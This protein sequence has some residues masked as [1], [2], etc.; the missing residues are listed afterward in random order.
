MHV[1]LR[2]W[3]AKEGRETSLFGTGSEIEAAST[4][5]GGMRKIGNLPI[6]RRFPVVA[7]RRKR[8]VQNREG[9]NFDEDR[10]N[11]GA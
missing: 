3:A 2:K 8:N 7:D 5:G 9:T 4:V 10:S 1:A 6:S 11:L